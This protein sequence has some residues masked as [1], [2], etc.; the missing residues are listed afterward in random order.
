[1]KKL[2]KK[3]IKLQKKAIKKGYTIYIKELPAQ[4][5]ITFKKL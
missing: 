3:L 1:M 2:I 5:L 4:N